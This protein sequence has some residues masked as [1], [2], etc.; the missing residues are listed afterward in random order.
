MILAY[1]DTKRPLDGAALLVIHAVLALRVPQIEA[2]HTRLCLFLM[3]RVVVGFFLVTV[4][5]LPESQ[6]QQLDC[7]SYP[8]ISPE[9]PKRK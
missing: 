4:A 3:F 8:F 2:N 7:Y 6:K 5:L 1:S 9:K